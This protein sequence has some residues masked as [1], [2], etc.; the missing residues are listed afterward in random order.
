M[1]CLEYTERY[2]K[3]HTCEDTLRVADKLFPWA[4]WSDHTPF[5]R[6]MP[7]EYKFDTNISTFD[8]YKMYIASKPWAADNYLR[9]PERKPEWI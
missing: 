4:P 2:G 8:A 3:K 1:L 7:D 5:A 9:K 6:A